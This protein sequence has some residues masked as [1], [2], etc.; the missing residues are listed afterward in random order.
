MEFFIGV[1]IEV[2]GAGQT[3]EDGFLLA[4]LL[5]LQRFVNGYPDGVAGLGGGQGARYLPTLS[6]DQRGLMAGF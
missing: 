4:G 6:R 1:H 3:E 5:A 2:A